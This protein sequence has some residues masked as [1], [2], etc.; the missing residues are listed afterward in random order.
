[1][2]LTNRGD[3]PLELRAALSDPSAFRL[4]GE[5][6]FT[7]QP[8]ESRV[9]TLRFVKNTG[10]K[11]VYESLLVLESP[12]GGRAEV[13]LAGLYMERPEGSRE[14]FLRG[15][16]QTFGYGTDLGA[17]AQGGFWNASPNSALAGDEVRAP[18]WRRADP[19]R[20]VEVRQLAAFH[21]CCVRSFTFELLSGGARIAA[22]RADRFHGQTL[23]PLREGAA[24]PAGVSAT[25]DAPFEVWV[26]GYSSDPTK[27][28]GAPNLGVRFWTAKDALGRPLPN[29]YLVAQDFV[30]QGCGSSSA[31]NC[32]FNDN[33][34]LIR[35]VEPA[36]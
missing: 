29:T 11:G 28:Q 8:G 2:Q 36:P 33:I 24:A 31:A 7:L 21:D 14:V 19:S 18:R 25:P 17:N 5:A 26:A 23:L 9:L 10:A 12:S 3:T 13:T 35:N 30:D 20:P 15:V 16:V 6:A 32:D 22:F 34:Y 1:L 4:E 27:G